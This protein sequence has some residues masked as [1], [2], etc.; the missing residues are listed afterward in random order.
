MLHD[1]PRDRHRRR[2]PRRPDHHGAR[3]R[4]TPRCR[5]PLRSRPA[6]SLI[7]RTGA[8]AL[9]AQHDNASESS[10]LG[11]PTTLRP[12][13]RS[14]EKLSSRRVSSYRRDDAATQRFASSRVRDTR[15]TRWQL[16]ASRRRGRPSSDDRRWYVSPRA[17]TYQRSRIRASTLRCPPTTGRTLGRLR[18]RCRER[19][20]KKNPIDGSFAARL[21]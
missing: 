9:A 6:W 7:K 15:K 16:S 14:C 4:K 17:R 20:G 18:C 11:Q 13:S 10:R 2:R 1:A 8:R 12:R 3:C 21:W 19:D 5:P